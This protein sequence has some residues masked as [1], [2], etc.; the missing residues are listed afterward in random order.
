M[1]D[2]HKTFIHAKTSFSNN[3]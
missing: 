3:M 1:A 2:L